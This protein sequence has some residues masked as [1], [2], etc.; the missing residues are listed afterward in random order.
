[1]ES[2]YVIVQGPGDLY[3]LAQLVS[4]WDYYHVIFTHHLLPVVRKKMN[5]H[6]NNDREQS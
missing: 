3:M 4:G 5:T 2:K 1:M 6:I